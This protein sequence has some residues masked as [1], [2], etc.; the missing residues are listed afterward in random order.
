MG[1]RGDDRKALLAWA[2]QPLVPVSQRLAPVSVPRNYSIEMFFAALLL[3][4]QSTPPRDTLPPRLAEARDAITAGHVER[5]IALAT[6]Y[7]RE[8]PDD[9]HG[10]LVLGDAYEHRPVTGRYQAWK[11]YRRAAELHPDDPAA[12][13]GAA[14]A[15]WMLGP[16]DGERLA[17]EGF[18]RV[19]AIDPAYRDTWERWSQLYRDDDG[20]RR[21]IA[22]LEKHLDIPAVLDWIA[23][24]QVE[25][26][27]DSAVDTVLRAG[28]ARHPTDP[29]LLALAAERAFDQGDLL[30][31]WKSY[32]AALARA[33]RDSADFLWHQAMSIASPAE[34]QEWNAGIPPG[35]RAAWLESFWERRN[36][37]LFSA[38]NQ[39]VAEQFTR[40]RYARRKFDAVAHPLGRV[41]RSGLYR[42][43]NL[44]VT[45][46]EHDRYVECEAKGFADR[47]FW[48]DQAMVA[49]VPEDAI[50]VAPEVVPAGFNPED[51]DTTVALE[52]YERVSSWGAEGVAYLRFG[53]P[54]VVLVGAPYSY[55][56]ACAGIG[57]DLERWEY[58]WGEL[59]FVRDPLGGNAMRLRP[60]SKAQVRAAQYFL[61]HDG[62]TVPMKL[63]FG[64]WT[65]QFRDTVA[66]NRIDVIV[67]ATRGHVAAE[68]IGRLGG[69]RGAVRSRSSRIELSAPPGVYQ[70]LA[71]AQDVDDDGH[72]ILGRQGQNLTLRDMRGPAMSDV[73][74]ARSWSG[75]VPS[76]ADALQHVDVSLTFTSQDT[77]RAYSELY[78]L[79]MDHGRAH[80]QVTYDILKTDHA[81]ADATTA[82]WSGGT[83]FTFTR[84]AVPSA[85]GIT[86]EVLDM[87][88]SMVGR[89]TFLLRLHVTDLVSGRM[90]GAPTS[91]FTVQ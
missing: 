34:I 65:A 18:E 50:G 21:V 20:R 39:R 2:S 30:T 67:M 88:P 19:L 10:F 14:L 63:D 81:N 32:Q 69:S 68:L 76:R 55:K 27:D 47:H 6:D 77:I 87:A 23:R 3:L 89:G 79:A 44:Q 35:Q 42:R 16:P 66:A 90:I 7:T 24:L 58:P 8:H 74:L 52:D 17:R 46:A 78:G 5:A 62:S 57:A 41:M 1:R 91:Q 85:D 56:P 26:G 51:L 72:R 86:R 43:D 29:V 73:L 61:W 36:P 15:G 53:A 70:L 59:R 54:T 38:I 45:F 25:L 75:T 80:Y 83:S 12:P 48:P 28:L 71:N 37:D 60:M 33:D 22:I 84:S 13:Y 11:A 64:L 82:Q 4:L 9:E 31:G 49:D 40:I